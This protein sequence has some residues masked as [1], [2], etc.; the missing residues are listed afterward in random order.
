MKVVFFYQG[1][2]R[3]PHMYIRFGSEIPQCF[4]KHGGVTHPWT[5]RGK[6]N[7]TWSINPMWLYYLATYSGGF[8]ISLKWYHEIFSKVLT[9]REN[10]KKCWLQNKYYFSK[11][12][13]HAFYMHDIPKYRTND[14]NSRITSNKTVEGDKDENRLRSNLIGSSNRTARLIPSSCEITLYGT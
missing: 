14:P 11:Y 12:S 8:L 10:W 1:G 3:S 13:Y 6:C 5:N 9:L 7:L 4:P 2:L